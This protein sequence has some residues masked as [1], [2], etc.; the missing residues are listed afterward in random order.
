MHLPV[1]DSQKLLSDVLGSFQSPDL[2]EILVAPRVRELVCL[3]RVVDGQQRDVVS[4]D[5]VE[6]GFFLV[7][8]R[9]FVFRTVTKL[10][11]GYLSP[12]FLSIICRRKH[13]DHFLNCKFAFF[14]TFESV[15]RKKI[16]CNIYR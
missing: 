9:L 14:I 1:H 10:Q 7:G 16:K 15:E 12:I 11:S 4:L 6:F 13:S 2:D 5:L 3:P 8:N